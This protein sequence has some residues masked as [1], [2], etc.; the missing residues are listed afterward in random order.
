[1]PRYGSTSNSSRYFAINNEATSES[2]SGNPL[3]SIDDVNDLW[4]DAF[5]PMYDETEH[6]RAVGSHF[7]R[8][9]FT[10]YWRI[11]QGIDRQL[12]RYMRGDR[13][14]GDTILDRNGIDEYLHT[15]YE[16]SKPSTG[17]GCS[18]SRIRVCEIP[19]SAI[20]R[21]EVALMPGH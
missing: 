18:G 14:E 16:D 10:T 19:C 12:L 21:R 6:H 13:V 8:H 1:M 11:D 7:G 20:W 3:S 2:V 17:R 5:R 4:K 9:F 15:Y